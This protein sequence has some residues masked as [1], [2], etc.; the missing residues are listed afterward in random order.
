MRYF[1]DTC[2][3][4]DLLEDRKN[5]GNHAARFLFR[6]IKRQDRVLINDFIFSE[7]KKSNIIQKVLKGHIIKV[8][9]SR[10]QYLEAEKLSITRGLPLVDC[11]ITILARD[12]KAYVIT[13]D[14]HIL[15]RLS[16]IAISYRP[17][18]II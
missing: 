17:E 2:V 8:R 10:Q 13:R 11:I 3:W 14:K 16:D 15:N 9:I 4:I 18:D 7:L 1:I 5:F 6:V 12:N